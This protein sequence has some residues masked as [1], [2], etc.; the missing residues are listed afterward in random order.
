MLEDERM[1]DS[2]VVSALMP[3]VDLSVVGWLVVDVVLVG[4][5]WW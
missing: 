5:H 4:V 2:L 3:V 1:V